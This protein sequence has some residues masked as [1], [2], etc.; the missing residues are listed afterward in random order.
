M[1]TPSDKIPSTGGSEEDGSR[2][3]A[4]L[5][6]TSPPHYQ[7]SYCG[8]GVTLPGDSGDGIHGLPVSG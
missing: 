2:D 7:L 1:L 6:T 8:P 4:T 3:V 5:R